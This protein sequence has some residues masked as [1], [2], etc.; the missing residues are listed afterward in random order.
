[1]HVPLELA[2]ERG[3]FLVGGADP[4]G[5]RA[6]RQQLPGAGPLGAR[7]EAGAAGE[8]PPGSVRDFVF[9]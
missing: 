1:V 3:G 6:Q 4:A 2:F 9:A 8:Q 5:E 7:A